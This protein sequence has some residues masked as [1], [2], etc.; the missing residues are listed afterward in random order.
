MENKARTR[1]TNR[2]EIVEFDLNKPFS[3]E[4]NEAFFGD[5]NPLPQRVE[6]FQLTPHICTV[7]EYRA[8]NLSRFAETLE[9]P[10]PAPV[11]PPVIQQAIPE[12]PH[13]ELAVVFQS[14]QQKRQRKAPAGVSAFVSN[15][16][17]DQPEENSQKNLAAIL[18]IGL[19]VVIIGACA[20][21]NH[22]QEPTAVS[23]EAA[24]QPVAEQP[25]AQPQLIAY[26]PASRS[27]R[28]HHR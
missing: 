28:R 13:E 17:H 9:I 14:V 25:A 27:H 12:K 4:E 7:E 16:H 22:P 6:E 20:L 23:Q 10:V 1:I 2:T 19:T 8:R 24:Q 26:Q 5:W 18:A 15:Y 21:F 11:L 3:D